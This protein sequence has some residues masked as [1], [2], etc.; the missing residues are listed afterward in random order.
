MY[1]KLHGNICQ[2]Y[3]NMSHAKTINNF[4]LQ[5]KRWG[6]IK[7]Q[8]LAKNSEDF[9][10]RFHLHDIQGV[11]NISLENYIV[12]TSH[13]LEIYKLKLLHL[14]ERFSKTDNGFMYIKRSA[15]CPLPS[16]HP[17]WNTFCQCCCK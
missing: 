15:F 4:L 5:E 8:L 11:M 6:I 13:N 1:K 10:K 14:H 12:Y 9:V 16:L 7:T 17:Q 3:R 2:L